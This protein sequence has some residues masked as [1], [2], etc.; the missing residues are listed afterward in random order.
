MARR[1]GASSRAVVTYTAEMREL[2]EEVRRAARE[3]VAAAGEVRAAA[4]AQGTAQETAGQQAVAAGRQGVAAQAQWT[5]ATRL[6]VREQERLATQSARAQ[7]RAHEQ[8]ARERARLVQQTLAQQET[9]A[10][11]AAVAHESSWRRISMAANKAS[12]I[13]GGNI[14]RLGTNMHGLGLGLGA[15]AVA[16]GLLVGKLIDL[17]SAVVSSERQLRAGSDTLRRLESS[18]RGARVTT[19]QLTAALREQ[20]QLTQGEATELAI[21]V[22]AQREYA[23]LLVGRVAPAIERVNEALGRLFG[24]PLSTAQEQQRTLFEDMVEIWRAGASAVRALGLET[25]ALTTQQLEDIRRIRAE[26]EDVETRVRERILRR[27]R[28]GSALLAAL[29]GGDASTGGG[30]QARGR[31]LTQTSLVQ[32]VGGTVIPGLDAGTASMLAQ[33][34]EAIQAEQEKLREA[35]DTQAALAVKAQRDMLEAEA[36]RQQRATALSNKRIAQIDR[37]IAAQAALRDVYVSAGF[38]IAGS[39]MD[40]FGALVDAGSQFAMVRQALVIAEGLFRAFVFGDA[41]A[42]A[43]AAAVSAALQGAISIASQLFGDGGRGRSASGSAG[44]ATPDT[45]SALVRRREERGDERPINLTLIFGQGD[46]HAEDESDRVAERQ[47]R[48]LVERGTL[49]DVLR[50]AL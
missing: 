40:A 7:V 31:D 29:E 12:T 30:G 17:G 15:A 19:D 3:Q 37:E 24:A 16:G 11:R 49:R 41:T 20:H 1:E 33:Q 13:V 8:S 39:A 34:S 21:R 32:E 43:Q 2:V 6:S 4:L 36:D 50:R 28:E 46:Y 44:A 14:S 48:R 27:G 42:P 10:Q 25:R 45:S 23:D 26:V 18:S 47:I 5:D 38:D 9:A 35:L 22:R